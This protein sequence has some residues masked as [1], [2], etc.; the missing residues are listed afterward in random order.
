MLRTDLNLHPRDLNEARPWTA[1]DFNTRQVRCLCWS[2]LKAPANQNPGK[3]GSK[4][5]PLEQGT[6]P[7]LVAGILG[8]FHERVK[9]ILQIV[10][11]PCMIIPDSGCPNCTP[12]ISVEEVRCDHRLCMYKSFNYNKFLNEMIIIIYLFFL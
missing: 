8:I 10:M 7:I 9:G 3:F 2:F 11:G 5:R 6:R 4:P 1:V 12:P